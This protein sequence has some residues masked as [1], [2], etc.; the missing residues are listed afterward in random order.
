MDEDEDYMF[1]GMPMEREKEM[2]TQKRKAII[3]A[4]R[5]QTMSEGRKR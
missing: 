5:L 2:S 1:H 4:G 3:D